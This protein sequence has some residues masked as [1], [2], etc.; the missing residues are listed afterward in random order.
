[1]IPKVINHATLLR[2]A[3]S[4]VSAGPDSEPFADKPQPPTSCRI[5]NASVIQRRTFAAISA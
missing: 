3:I 2:T 1:M 5:R 4:P